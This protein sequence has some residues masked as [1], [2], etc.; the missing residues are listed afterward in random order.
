MCKLTEGLLNLLGNQWLL[1]NMLM[2]MSNLLNFESSQRDKGCCK[3]R[4]KQLNQISLKLGKLYLQLV[5][6]YRCIDLYLIK[7][8]LYTLL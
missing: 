8:N 3:H 7:V 6:K 1:V 2:H 5:G 4:H